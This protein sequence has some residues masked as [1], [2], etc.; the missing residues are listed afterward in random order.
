MQELDTQRSLEELFRG[1]RTS[2]TGLAGR[3]ATRRQLVHG[4]NELTRKGGRRFCLR[5]S[6][7]Q[8]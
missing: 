3:E 1:L 2:A 6:G 8:T 5:G 4:A 7:T